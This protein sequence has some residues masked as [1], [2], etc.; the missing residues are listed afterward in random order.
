[1][2]KKTIELTDAQTKEFAG[3]YGWTETIIDEDG[4]EIQNPVTAEEVA[5]N[6]IE[7][8]INDSVFAF[9]K[10]TYEE[11]KEAEIKALTPNIKLKIVAEE[12]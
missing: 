8:Y 10:E 6:A 3:Q 2:Y 11:S 7:K 9:K 12:K 1:M 4:K 5:T